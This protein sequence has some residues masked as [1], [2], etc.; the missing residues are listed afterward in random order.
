V[1]YFRGLFCMALIFL[2]LSGA[3]LA[4]G[5]S[6]GVEGGCLVMNAHRGHFVNATYYPGLNVGDYGEVSFET[7][8]RGGHNST[9]WVSSF[10]LYWRTT[11]EWVCL[12]F[13]G[14]HYAV[15]GVLGGKGFRYR[16]PS[17]RHIGNWSDPPTSE[18]WLC[19]N[20]NEWNRFKITLTPSEI[21]F[22]A[23]HLDE[24][25]KYLCTLERAQVHEEPYVILGKGYTPNRGERRF[26]QAN[27]S[28]S[29]PSDFRTLYFD[30][31]IVRVDDKVVLHDTFH[32]KDLSKHW[33]SLWEGDPDLESKISLLDGM[34]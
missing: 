4:D 11:D 5:E 17:L 14:S 3:A 16:D 2:I 22:Y 30:D 8:I 15:Q 29:A 1:K 20:Y 10:F 27:S 6:V 7:R 24:E 23:A 26:Y 12:R 32:G 19:P 34:H 9:S 31:F 33:V 28:S 21:R 13:I 18:D 25:W